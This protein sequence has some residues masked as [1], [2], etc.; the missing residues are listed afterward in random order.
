MIGDR[1]DV[2]VVVLLIRCIGRSTAVNGCMYIGQQG[3]FECGFW[4]PQIHITPWLESCC[5][6]HLPV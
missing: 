2:C 6:G 1:V 5:L 3:V 4:K